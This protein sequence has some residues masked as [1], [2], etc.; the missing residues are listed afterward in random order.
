MLNLLVLKAFIK[1]E[2]QSLFAIAT[3]GGF[4]SRFYKEFEKLK[5]QIEKSYGYA[6]DLTEGDLTNEIAVIF[7]ENTFAE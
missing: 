7:H 3:Y 5:R 6:F 1:L 2:F 4:R